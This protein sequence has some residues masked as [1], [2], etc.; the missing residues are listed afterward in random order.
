MSR[1]LS[2]LKNIF[3]SVRLYRGKGMRKFFYVLVAGSSLFAKHHDFNDVK[4]INAKLF[5]YHVI[6]DGYNEMLAERSVN[7]ILLSFDPVDLYFL[8]SEKST[9]QSS[10]K[11]MVEEYNNGTFTTYLKMQ[12]T[13][14]ASVK[15]CRRIRSEVRSDFIYD[16]IDFNGQLMRTSNGAPQSEL[17]QKKN[18]KAYMAS[19]LRAYA[20]SRGLQTLDQKD[21]IRVL[22]Y[23]ERR[24]QAHEERFLSKETYP[25]VVSKMI[26][27]SLDAHSMVYGE[28]EISNINSHLKSKFEGIG[29]YIGDGIDGP[30]IT[31]CVK[32]G[33]AER[34]TVIQPGDRI[35]Y[36]N[37]VNARE[38]SFAKVMNLLSVK[39]GAQIVLHVE[40]VDGKQK[41]VKLTGEKIT[42]KK[43]KIVIETESFLDGHIA[44]L[45]VDTF[46]NDFEGNDMS[47][48]LKN[49]ILELKRQKPLYGVIIDMRKNLGGFF[50]E[51]VKS[52]ALFSP[53]KTVVVAKFRDDQVRY[54]TEF[55]LQ[56]AYCGPIVILTSKY[57]A[58]AAEILAQSLQ[59]VG[60]AIIAGDES[61]F[62][63]GSIQFQT[64]TD[65]NSEH[66]YKVTVGKYYTIS[67]ASTQLKGV[68][69]DI[70][71][72]SIYS[73]RKIGEKYLTYALPSGDLN[74]GLSHHPEVR[75][76]FEYQSSRK[77]TAYEIMKPHLK[78]NSELR[79]KNNK[80]Y[81]AFLKSL[82]EK[83]LNESLSD[84]EKRKGKYG[85]NDLQ[86]TEA[87]CIIKDMHSILKSYE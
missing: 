71:V 6:F 63:K 36:V 24:M 75:D 9:F 58:S 73:K 2:S 27:S 68:C 69:A 21:K 82:D 35:T 62:G 85:T 1:I 8:E 77:K 25:L 31:G 55:N 59:D 45:S 17:E 26:A 32:G 41:M 87:T 38:V 5:S 70:L 60:I 53:Q 86:M 3:D 54:S 57:S 40:S 13:F 52:I 65:P 16:K 44:K 81:Q 66:K 48:D 78:K 51:A 76:I 34:S 10:S 15:R 28:E 23:Y 18:I 74:K 84:Q 72:P 56:V 46:Y 4:T 39:D 11:V 14:G 42:M 30:V 83:N 67:G 33:P 61:S 12:E 22:D 7:K 79:V 64:I 37:G 49:V 20:A 29:V 43:D 80:N 47:G 19:H 50:K